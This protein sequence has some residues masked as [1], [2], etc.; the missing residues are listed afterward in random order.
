MTRGIYVVAFGTEARK[1]AERCIASCREHMPSVPVALCSSAPL[2]PEDVLVCAPDSDV[3]GRRAKLRAYDLAPQE[4]ESVLY[5]DADTELVAPVGQLFEWVESG[6]DFVICR[7]VGDTCHSFHRKNNEREYAELADALGTLYAL[8]FNGGVW[9]FRRSD[10]TKA[11]MGRWL[12]EWEVHAQR[13]Q[14]ALMRALYADPMR[15][16]VLG[17]EWNCF[18][19]YT[20]NIKVPRIMHYPG[21]ARRWVGKLPGRIDSPAAWAR[22]GKRSAPP[23]PVMPRTFRRPGARRRPERALP[24]PEYRAEVDQMPVRLDMTGS[25]ETLLAALRNVAKDC[26]AFP[27]V[28][29]KVLD[30]QMVALYHLARQFDHPGARLLE[31]GTGHGGSGYM[32]GHAAPR[33]SIVSVT[34][35]P[36]EMAA[37]KLWRSCGIKQAWVTV[38]ASWDL[39]AADSAVWDLVFIDGDHNRIARDLPWFDRL[40]VGGLLLC[41]DYS[42][43][44][45][46]TPSGVVF[47][48]LNAMAE[49]LGRPFDVRIVDE[50]KVGMV[51]FYRRE[52]EHA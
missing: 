18:P 9:A 25:Q 13:D 40:R 14:G 17:N 44:D 3:G 35:N 28:K 11:F 41:H 1:C 22:V 12:A 2:G 23:V 32:F 24:R 46:R 7:D 6:W 49:R 26:P 27:P 51:G 21:D 20:P 33:A 52:G 4:W 16:L 5:L 45:S 8:Q 29:R 15:V 38:Q 42:P 34:T 48:E 43:D 37:E 39:L 50:G 30:Y 19:K 36:A 31:I 47:S 10:A